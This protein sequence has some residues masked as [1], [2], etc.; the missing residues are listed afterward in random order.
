MQLQ[1][2][3][4]QFQ[5]DA[6]E[7]VCAVF[8]GQRKSD[9]L[10]FPRD[11]GKRLNQQISTDDVDDD[12]LGYRN[13]EVDLSDA[14]LLRNIHKIQN[15]SNV[16][17]SASLDKSLGA[18][19]IDVEMETGTGKTYVYIKTMFELNERYGWSKFIVVVPSIAIREGVKKTFEITSEHFM[20][21]YKKKARFFVY[22]SKNLHKLD[23]FSS[24]FGI[25]VMIINTQAFAATLNEEKNVTGRKGNDVSRLIYSKQ[26]KFNSRRPIDVI[27]ANRPIII[28]DEPQKMGGAVTQNALK[29]NFNPLFSLN[30]S[31]THKVSHNLV[32]VLDALDAFK[33]KLVKKIE[34]KGFEISHLSGT[35]GYIYFSE[36]VLSPLMEPKARL[37]IDY[38]LSGGTVRRKVVLMGQGDRLLQAS[39]GL[40]VYKDLFVAEVNTFEGSITFSNNEKLYV[41]EASGNILER[42]IRRVQIRETILSHFEKERRLFENGIKCLSLFFIDEVSKYRQYDDDGNEVLGEYGLIFEEEYN[43]ALNELLEFENTPYTDYLQKISGTNTHAGYFSID[44]KGRAVNSDIKRGLEFSDDVTAYDLILKR[45]ELLLTLSAEK[46]PVRFIFSHSALREGWDN[47]NVFNICALKQSENA[48]A[49]RQEVGRGLRLCVD[50]SGIRQDIDVWGEALVQDINKLTVVTSESYTQFVSDLQ[51]KIKD[52][53]YSR[54]TKA[55]VAYF[56]GKTIKTGEE[57]HVITPSEATKIYNYLIRNY[58][59][60][61]DGKV[62]EEYR[63]AEKNGILAPLK[64]ELLP[65]SDGIHSLIRAIFDEKAFNEMIKPKKKAFVKNKIID[66]NWEAFKDLWQRINKR[67]AYLVDFESSTLVEKAA[68]EVNEGLAVTELHYT[69]IQGENNDNLDFKITNTSTKKLAR[70]AKVNIKYDLV[71]KIADGVNLSRRTVMEILSKLSV[72]K[73][74]MFTTNPEEFISKVIKIINDQKAAIVVQCISYVPSAEP[75]YGREIFN[76]SK[77]SEE[78][79]KAYAARKAIQE[80]VFTDGSAQ[81]S[82]EGK[83]VKDLDANDAVVVYAK[84]PKGPKGFYI[85]TPVGN[86]SPDWAISF[87]KASVRYIYFIAETKGTMDRT[88]FRPIEDAKIDCAM[89]LFNDISTAGVK[90]HYVDSYKTLVE[91]VMAKQL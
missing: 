35:D 30:Y 82:I 2:K 36:I 89:K 8:T 63:E 83:F 86:Y 38:K 85:P 91:E 78:Y 25:N 10:K 61:D 84:L 21:E 81:E 90:Y 40:T 5:T 50:Q 11:M 48:T 80:F 19:S 20:C 55:E 15:A 52:D 65:L 56:S 12:G 37:E 39:G 6:V 51:S 47:P 70:S 44:K 88:Q 46:S 3:E 9:P 68:K 7:A 23:E 49:K 79:E 87:K 54:P 41:S 43:D 57:T 59:V 17:Q 4:Q 53:L 26:D 32:Y 58:Y 66:A 29:S 1:F 27:K 28:L 16:K 42:D 31:A 13:A 14:E 72:E 62:T 74:S 18:V 60:D 77:E 33:S 64:D 45:K 69:K 76:M 24:G 73:I 75:E 71:Q 22:D 34:V 67:Y